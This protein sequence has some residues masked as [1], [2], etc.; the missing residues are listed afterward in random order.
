MPNQDPV[1]IKDLFADIPMFFTRNSFTND[2]NVKK[3]L[4]A[5]RESIK[6]IVLT[7]KGE[8]AFDYDFGGNI[9]A[10]LFENLDRVELYG[11]KI[12]LANM[13]SMYEPRVNVNEIYFDFGIHDIDITIEYSIVY[14]NTKDKITIKLERSR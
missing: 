10:L 5:I 6:N 9:Y 14:I 4:T 1:I 11:F 13:I 3:D 7:N 12:Q 8:R 2:L